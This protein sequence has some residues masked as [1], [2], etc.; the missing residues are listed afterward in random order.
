MSP[1]DI[2]SAFEER[3]QAVHA[4]RTLADEARDREFTAEESE[5]YDRQNTSIDDLD[6]RIDTGLRSLQR[7]A[8]AAEAAGVRLVELDELMQQ[9]DFVSIHCPLTDATRDLIGPD[10]ISQMKSNAYL[11]NTARGGIVN[12]DALYGALLEKRIAGAALDCFVGEPIKSPHRFGELDNV[13]LAPHSIAWT[14]EL[15]R[16]IGI[17]ACR[18]MVDLSRGKKPRGVV[19]QEVFDR[20]GFQEKWSRHMVAQGN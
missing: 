13:L 6:A 20:P 10:Q 12:E 3:Q 18:S 7:E 19:N 5:V 17:T 11:L 14:E 2:A 8:K 15:F 1:Q 9:A 4:L 16:D